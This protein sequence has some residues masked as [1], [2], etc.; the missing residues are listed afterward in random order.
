MSEDAAIQT[1][2]AGGGWGYLVSFDLA[3]PTVLFQ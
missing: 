2:I 3:A 1:R